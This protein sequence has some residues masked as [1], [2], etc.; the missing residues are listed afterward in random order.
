[1]AFTLEKIADS[2]NRRLIADEKVDLWCPRTG[3]LEYRLAIRHIE[4]AGYKCRWIDLND[5]A[6][7]VY[8]PTERAYRSWLRRHMPRNP[9]VANAKGV[10]RQSRPHWRRF[11]LARRRRKTPMEWEEI[12]IEWIAMTGSDVSRN[13]VRCAARRRENV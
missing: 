11:A 2:F 4:A 3:E 1:M 8:F 6:P 9:D 13:C 12:R 10:A 7:H 5:S